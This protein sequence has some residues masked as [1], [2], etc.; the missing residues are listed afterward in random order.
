[1]AVFYFVTIQ[2]LLH[3]GF[4]L[5]SCGTGLCLLCLSIPEICT[6]PKRHTIFCDEIIFVRVFAA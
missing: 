6:E 5:N 1:M 4:E 3:C 2:Q